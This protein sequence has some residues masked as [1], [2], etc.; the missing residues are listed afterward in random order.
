MESTCPHLGADLSHADIE[1]TDTGLVAVCPWHRYDFDLRTGHSE[2]GL[3]ACTYRV[4][5]RPDESDSKGPSL[6]VWIESPPC[7]DD[8]LWEVVELRP[9]SEGERCDCPGGERICC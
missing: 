2:T 5:T 1:D 4:E 8:G 3:T 9:V 6:M 7:E